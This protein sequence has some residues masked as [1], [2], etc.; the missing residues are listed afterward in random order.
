MVAVM[1]ASK[2]QLVAVVTMVMVLGVGC[3]DIIENGTDDCFL[4]NDHFYGFT[5]S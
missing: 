5:L 3:G 1:A 4:V 2:H